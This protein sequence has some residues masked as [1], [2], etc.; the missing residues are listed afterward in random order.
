VLTIR[1][2]GCFY[3]TP[4]REATPI[5][6]SSVEEFEGEIQKQNKRKGDNTM[7]LIKFSDLNLS[8]ENQ[9]LWGEEEFMVPYY[10]WYYR[11]ANWENSNKA[12]GYTVGFSIPGQK[13]VGVNYSTLSCE[14][15]A[16]Y[17]FTNYYK[18]Y[19]E[20]F[21]ENYLLIG[22]SDWSVCTIKDIPF[23]YTVTARTWKQ[24][25]NIENLREHVN[26]ADWYLEHESTVPPDYYEKIILVEQFESKYFFMVGNCGYILH[27][28][29]ALTN[30]ELNNPEYALEQAQLSQDT[31]FAIAE[32]LINQG[33]ELDLGGAW[34]NLPQEGSPYYVEPGTTA[35]P[36]VICTPSPAPAE[37]DE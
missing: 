29:Y 7:L 31:A 28:C 26:S 13:T 3:S 30:E 37:E 18:S 34:L 4:R 20:F 14:R 12:R 36:A 10:V 2:V 17:T 15:S 27:M 32:N 35:P 11:K 22:G 33:K 1:L 16:Q 24:N 6:F 9:A 23:Y 19:D 21:S 8:P 5:V 25:A